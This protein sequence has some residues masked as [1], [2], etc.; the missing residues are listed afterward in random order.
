M[1]RRVAAAL[2]VAV[3]A[4]MAVVAGAV[5]AGADGDHGEGGDPCHLLTRKEITRVFG[6][7]A[8][9]P[10]SSLG[11][12][13]CQWT[14]AATPTQA[15]GQVNVVLEVGK[16]AAR[17]Y[18]TGRQLAGTLAEPVAGLGKKAFFTPDT[19][20]LFVLA[21]GPTLFY[22]QANVYDGDANRITDGLAATLTTLATR[23]EARV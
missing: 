5:P 20:T 21:A 19:G 7:K 6:Q 22:V 3:A 18:K 1:S 2:V 10:S 13:F 23:A 14:L 17:D 15:P 12:T 9:A 16:V 4:V 8:S 11:P